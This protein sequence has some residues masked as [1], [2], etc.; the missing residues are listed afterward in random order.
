MVLLRPSADSPELNGRF[1]QP[2]VIHE[3][4]AALRY[5]VVRLWETPL[6]DLLS[7]G[8]GVAMLAPLGK[9]EPADVPAVMRRMDERASREMPP[10]RLDELRAATRFLLGL[11]YDKHQILAWMQRDVWI[12]ESSL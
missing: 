7:G 11:R 8:L 6:E 10:S 5:R 12:R 1:E 3:I 4:T 9:V 2:G